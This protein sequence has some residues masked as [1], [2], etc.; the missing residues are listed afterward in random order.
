MNMNPHDTV[1]PIL[2]TMLHNLQHFL[3]RAEADGH[4]RGYD[5][6]VLMQSRLAPDMLSLAGQVRYACISAKGGAAK[7]SGAVVPA[8]DPNDDA[9]LAAAQVRITDTLS[10]LAA[11]PQPAASSGADG[12]T[13]KVGPDLKHTFSGPDFAKHWVL[14]H[15]HFHVAMAYA[16]LRHNGVALG[17][18]DYIWGALKPAVD[19]AA[20]TAGCAPAVR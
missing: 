5:T 18:A 1:M 7:L 3:Q 20:A 16:L 8:Y 17:K 14:S 2:T 10:W 15:F 12:Y 11:L 19:S 13:V 4:A 6:Q 9:T